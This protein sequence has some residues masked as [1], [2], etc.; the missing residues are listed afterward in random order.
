VVIHT[1]ALLDV[2]GVYTASTPVGFSMDIEYISPS[3]T[4]DRPVTT[5]EPICTDGC[6]CLTVLEAK[7]AGF[8][9][10]NGERTECGY[11][12]NQ[13]AMYCFE[14]YEA[15][16]PAGCVCMSEL[17]AKDTGY[18][19]C[20][21][22]RTQ[23]GYDANQNPMYCFEPQEV[24]CPTGCVCMSEL[25]A[26][27]T[28]YT[29]CNGQRT[30]CGY[31]ANQNPMYCFEPQEVKCPTGCRCLTEAEAKGYG[32]TLCNGQRTQCGTNANGVA[33]Y[34]FEPQEVKCPT[35]CECM[36]EV[37]AKQYGYTLCNGQRTQCG[38]DAS[39]A[40]LY[41]FQKPAAE[42][43]PARITVSPTQDRNPV[44]TQHTITIVVY[45]ANGKP[46]PGKTLKIVHSG[47]H[48]IGPLYFVTGAN[49]SYNYTY[50]GQY[51][52][53][54]KIVVTVDS[55]SATAYKDWYIQPGMTNR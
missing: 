53:T 21:G 23:C 40:A 30:Q 29:L 12:D 51:T 52:G 9:L 10:C 20:N 5:G 16:C 54:D 36:T 50:K 45:D 34:C 27:D 44:G 41:C 26:K 4:V 8:D 38:T 35:G 18:T 49:G 46:M 17:K 15:K 37:Q 2:V 22:Q 6:K 43:G 11:D 7:E 42:A 14:P 28:G 13:N 39:G 1:P 55:V 25:K 48:S 32:Y 31:D 24:K 19:L 3:T 47:A 33:L